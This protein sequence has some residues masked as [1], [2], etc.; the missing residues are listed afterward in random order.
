MSVLVEN[1]F[2]KKLLLLNRDQRFSKE[3]HQAIQMLC[4]KSPT[5]QSVAEKMGTFSSTVIRRFFFDQVAEQQLVSGVTLPKAI[6]IDAYKG[7]TNAG[8]FQLIITNAETHE[9][10][11]ILPNR[12]K[13]TIKQYLQ[14][15]GDQVEIQFHSPQ[16]LTQS[17]FLSDLRS[18]YV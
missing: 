8:K 11:A 7:D 5:F 18:L 13:D 14:R 1:V 9:P 10:I 12:R 16:H 17:P 3:W 15:F 2:Q 4:V 6:A